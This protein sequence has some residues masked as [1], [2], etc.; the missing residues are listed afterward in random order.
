V[1]VGFADRATEDIFHG[2][3][4]KAARNIP[5]TLWAVARRKLDMLNGAQF[6]QDLTVPPANRLEKLR[7][8]LAGRYSIRIND[9]YRIVFRFDRGQAS[10]VLIT[11][12]H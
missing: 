10:D 5:K 3:E 1:I 12:Y 6:I 11:D 8:S 9:Q 4:T 7:G 2:S